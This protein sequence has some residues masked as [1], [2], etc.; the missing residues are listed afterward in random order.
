MLCRERP[1]RPSVTCFQHPITTFQCGVVA[2]GRQLFDIRGEVGLV[3]LLGLLIF[4]EEL[5]LEVGHLL[6]R[7]DGVVAPNVGVVASVAPIML[8]P[9]ALLWGT[10]GVTRCCEAATEMIN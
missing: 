5:L 4:F 10:R 7:V 1:R 8:L 3:V 9:A 2:L 6:F